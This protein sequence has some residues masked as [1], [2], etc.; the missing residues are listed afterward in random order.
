VDG[1][2]WIDETMIY[3]H[4]AE[5]HRREIPACVLEAGQA[6]TDPA[7][8]VLECS[9]PVANRGARNKKGCECSPFRFEGWR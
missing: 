4:V 1:H 7:R 3:L 5:N 9:M 8:R 2:K 6:E